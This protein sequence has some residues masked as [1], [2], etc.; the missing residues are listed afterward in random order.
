[1]TTKPYTSKSLPAAV[2]EVRRLRRM[3]REL[4][5]IAN[6]YRKERD[7]M[8]RLAAEKPQFFN[9][10]DAMDAKKLRDDILRTIPGADV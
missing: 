8:A 3:Y 7:A 5:A 4:D 1:M 2:R 10:L 9:P 6:R